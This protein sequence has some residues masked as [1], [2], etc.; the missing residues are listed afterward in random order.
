MVFAPNKNMFDNVKTIVYGSSPMRKTDIRKAVSFFGNKLI[1]LYGLCEV[2]GG[3]AFM[4]K[5]DHSKIAADPRGG[6]APV[7]KVRDS[8]DLSIRNGNGEEVRPG[9]VG[10][11]ASASSFSLSALSP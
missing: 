5:D 9:E 4:S 10:R 8:M 7:G 2:P 1:Q 3:I 6:I 11:G